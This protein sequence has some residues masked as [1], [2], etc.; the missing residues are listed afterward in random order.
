MAKVNAP[1]G[2]GVSLSGGVMVFHADLNLRWFEDQEGEERVRGMFAAGL[3]Y[4][5]EE[6]GL[7]FG[8]LLS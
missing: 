4:I 8:G 6:S 1:G 2:A 5:G 7:E 3:R